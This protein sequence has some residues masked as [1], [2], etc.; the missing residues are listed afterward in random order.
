LPLTFN[1]PAWFAKTRPRVGTSLVKEAVPAP[2]PRAAFGYLIPSGQEGRERLLEALLKEGFKATASS[3]P[4]SC[5]GQIFQ[6][7]TAIFP[8]HGNGGERLDERIA[9]LSSKLGPAVAVDSSHMDLG[10]DLGSDRALVLRAPRVAVIMDAPTNPTAVGA[11]E[12]TLRE[13]GIPFAQLRVQRLG[14][15][16]LRKYTHVILVDDDGQGKGYQAMLGPSGA[17]RLKSFAQEGGVLIAMQGGAAFASRSG[18][19]QAACR[20]LSP[21][22][23]EARTREKDSGHEILPRD[24]A[25]LTNAWS[26][27]EDRELQGNAPG[28]LLRARVD[29]THPLG[30]GLNATESAI[31]DT[32]D[33]ILELSPG[34]E[35]P[36]HYPGGELRVSGLLAK[37]L[38]PRLRNTSY[39]LREHRGKGAVILF[40]GDPVYRGNAPFTT[41]A[42]L[43]AL[44]F[45]GYA[46]A[47]AEE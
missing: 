39:L 25:G 6:A 42:F 8:R 3:A 43:N 36:I 35:N 21:Q 31:L 16:E 27:M 46:K 24:P 10:P 2:L 19:C 15:A 23:E 22:D 45:G 9:E 17:A 34:G 18:L 1:V 40:A 29:A 33:V 37:A 14:E 47:D 38:E 44:F 5:K 26:R 30:W 13:N 11:V 4:F 41:R 7:G 32:S 12:H 28:V 20:F